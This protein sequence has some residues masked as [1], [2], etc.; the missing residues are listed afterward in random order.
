M[1]AIEAATSD[2]KGNLLFT[3]AELEWFSRSSYN[4]GMK[5]ASD[6]TWRPRKIIQILEACISICG[7][8]PQ[9][10][11]APKLGDLSLKALFCHFMVA[12][13]LVALARS[14]DDSEQRDA[15]YRKMR[16]HVAAFDAELQG[17]LKTLGKPEAE[18][19][20]GKL[21]VLFIF[22]FEGCLALGEWQTLGETV[23]KAKTCEN[24]GM[25][26]AMGDCLLRSDAPAN[27]KWHWRVDTLGQAANQSHCQTCSR[28]CGLLSTNS[29]NSGDSMRRS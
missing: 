26:Q 22:D 8:F 27:R 13:A 18:D 16:K 15:D 2:E 4:L 29:S 17:L 7:N 14:E 19:L 21:A 6:S 25:Y 11:E 23:H 9:D 3:V 10:L 5:H 20:F 24:V 12:S 1:A 28:R